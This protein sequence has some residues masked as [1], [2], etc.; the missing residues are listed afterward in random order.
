MSLIKILLG[1]RDFAALQ[2]L[3]R[4]IANEESNTIENVNEMLLFESNVQ[5]TWLICT[6]HALYCALDD[7]RR[8]ESTIRWKLSKSSIVRGNTIFLNLSIKD[9]WK[10]PTKY[11]RIDFG[12]KH[13]DW[14]YSK[15]L[16]SRPVILQSIFQELIIVSMI[17]K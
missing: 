1:Y 9:D 6:N 5:K 8:D 10:K 7:I 14:L 17:E 3:R 2:D 12:S 16:Y 15:S 13:K 4:R 11:G